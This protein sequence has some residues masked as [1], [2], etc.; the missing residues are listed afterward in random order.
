HL[1][2]LWYQTQAGSP[3]IASGTHVKFKPVPRTNDIQR[4]VYE[5]NP[6]TSMPVVQALFYCP[7]QFALTDR[8]PLMWAKI[9]P[10]VNFTIQLEYPELDTFD[11]K[12]LSAP[13]RNF[14]DIRQQYFFHFV[15]VSYRFL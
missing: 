8:P 11:R 14:I 2:T 10:G 13:F 9:S 1:V 15:S 6:Q 12:Y 7:H 3:C 4:P 5:M